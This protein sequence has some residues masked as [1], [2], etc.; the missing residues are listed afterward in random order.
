MPLDVAVTWDD[1]WS[2][3]STPHGRMISVIEELEIG[4]SGRLLALRDVLVS[5]HGCYALIDSP[6]VC[7]LQRHT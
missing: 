4:N 3:S 7:H 2:G 1:H 6:Q 5:I